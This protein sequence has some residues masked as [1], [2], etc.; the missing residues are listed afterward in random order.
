[1]CSMVKEFTIA[2]TPHPTHRSITDSSMLHLARTIILH[3]LQ[4]HIDHPTIRHNGLY[5]GHHQGTTLM[6]LFILVTKRTSWYVLVCCRVRG[7]KR[8]LQ[9]C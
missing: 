4:L 1:M 8:G 5:I 2:H 7:C 3:I 9:R 6:N